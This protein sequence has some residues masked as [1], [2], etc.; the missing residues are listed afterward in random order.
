MGVAYYIALDNGDEEAAVAADGKAF[1]GNLDTLEAIAAKLGLPALDSFMGISDEEIDAIFED[2]GDIPD[3]D[4][5]WFEP[6]EGIAL[7]EKLNAHI[8]AHPSEIKNTE[9][10][11]QDIQDYLAILNKARDANARWRFG[12]DI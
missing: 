5:T 8:V 10:V 11:L 12:I 7:F 1:A 3:F 9:G 4:E 2:D 6:D